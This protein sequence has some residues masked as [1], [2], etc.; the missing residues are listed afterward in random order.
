MVEEGCGPSEALST[1]LFQV[2]NEI[3]GDVHEH[4]HST[5][6]ERP[7]EELQIH[8][9][10]SKQGGHGLELNPVGMGSSV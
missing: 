3:I 1:F 10:A 7:A 6:N 4:H 8:D 9:N 2:H 5:Q